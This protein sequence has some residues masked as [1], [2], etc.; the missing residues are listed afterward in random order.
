MEFNI[1]ESTGP[2]VDS[3]KQK[4]I[5]I[6]SMYIDI[7]SILELRVEVYHYTIA[8]VCKHLYYTLCYI[9]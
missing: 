6:E 9:T 5:Y 1:N 8:M 4:K 7:H 2:E 3:I